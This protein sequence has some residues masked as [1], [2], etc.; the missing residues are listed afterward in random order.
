MHFHTQRSCGRQNAS[1]NVPLNYWFNDSDIRRRR[2][3]ARMKTSMTAFLHHIRRCRYT[4][5]AFLAVL[6]SSHTFAATP[7]RVTVLRGERQIFEGFGANGGGFDFQFGIGGDTHDEWIEP[8]IKD[9]ISKLLWDK[10]EMNLQVFRW[11]HC[12]VTGWTNATIVNSSRDALKHRLKYNPEAK[13]LFNPAGTVNDPYSWAERVAEVIDTLERAIVINGRNI[14]IE[15]TGIGNEPNQHYAGYAAPMSSGTVPEVI[16]ALRNVL[17]MRGLSH[18][19]IIAPGPSNVDGWMW[20]AVEA[21]M[22]D[23]EAMNALYAWE[24][25]SYNMSLTEEMANY[26]LQTGKPIWQTEASL[27][28]GEGVLYTNIYDWAD[29]QAG[30]QLSTR[31]LADMNFGVN[32]WLHYVDAGVMNPWCP[33]CNVVSYGDYN[34]ETRA[35][36]KFYYFRQLGRTFV[37]GTVIRKCTTDV[38]VKMGEAGR[39]MRTTD[40]YMEYWYG[41]KIPLAASA[42][43][44]PDGS[45]AMAVVN[46]TDLRFTDYGSAYYPKTDFDVTFHVEEL[47]DEPEIAF[48]VWRMNAGSRTDNAGILETTPAMLRYG[49]ITVR[50]N[51]CDLVCLARD[52][53]TEFMRIPSAVSQPQGGSCGSCGTGILMSLIPPFSF[54]ASLFLKKR[55]RR[56]GFGRRT[57]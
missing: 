20:D 56:A 12:W 2:L 4:A 33:G 9:S 51:H 26:L 15:Y 39:D 48:K 35:H 10:N 16:K 23:A 25:H 30:A 5:S 21:V 18:V 57:R 46:H 11:G 28:E 45:W 32:Y 22:A 27:P 44:R 54:R 19:N 13:L 6:A 7:V 47:E 34:G 40:K 29:S 8:D 14:R 37:P 17:D 24:Y 52:F 43:L 38:H 50:V 53:E 31:F 1:C 49:D 3:I 55:R 41:L 36:L 42:G